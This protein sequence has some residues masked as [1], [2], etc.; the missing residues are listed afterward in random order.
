MSEQV[1]EKLQDHSWYNELKKYSY[2]VTNSK[3]DAEDVVQEAALKLYESQRSSK[4]D[5]HSLSNSYLRKTIKHLSIDLARKNSRVQLT[6]IEDTLIPSSRLEYENILAL[7]QFLVSNLTEV[8]VKVFLLK[9]IFYY[10]VSE[11]AELLQMTDYSVKSMLRRARMN[12]NRI[13]R[14]A[15]EPINSSELVNLITKA[16]L[17]NN[18]WPILMAPSN[19]VVSFR[20][21][22]STQENQTILFSQHDGKSVVQVIGKTRTTVYSVTNPITWQRLAA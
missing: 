11:I 17:L 7:S 1:D 21:Q 5:I 19:Q 8:Q 3:W 18:P 22:D 9:E 12:V 13:D 14:E 4:V 6:D 16:I 2:Y 10:Q 15:E 20:P